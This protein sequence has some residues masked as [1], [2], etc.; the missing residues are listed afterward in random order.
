MVIAALV[1]IYYAFLDTFGSDFHRNVDDT[2]LTPVCGQD[3]KL[4]GIE[5]I[6]SISARHIRQKFQGVL[7]NLCMEAAHAFLRVFHRPF[8][9]DLYIFLFQRFQLKDAGSGDQSAVYFKIRILCSGADQDHGAIL[10]KWKQIILL[11]FVKPVDLVDKE[12][13]LSSVHPL[14][15]FRLFYNILHILFSRYRGIDLLEL[16]AGR[17]GDHPCKCSLPRARR[18]VKDDGA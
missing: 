10:Y 11:A 4:Y 18:S 17:V 1:I 12:D 7:I 13:R 2:V 14:Q 9:K 6:S 8:Q 15:V 5:R 16:R 3:S